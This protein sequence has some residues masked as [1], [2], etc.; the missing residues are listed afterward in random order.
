MK[1]VLVIRLRS[2]GDTV[3]A[4]PSLI[5]LKRFLPHA[6]VDI[7]LEDWVAPLLD[8]FDAVEGVITVGKGALAKLRTARDI[9]RRKYDVV[10]NLHGG[11]T[12][13][14]FT[15]LSGARHRIGYSYYQYPFLYNHLLSSSSDFWKAEQTHSAEQQLALLG[16]VGVPVEDRPRSRLVVT[17]SAVESLEK[18]FHEKTQGSKGG[19]DSQPVS[20]ITEQVRTTCVSGWL[21]IGDFALFHPAAAFATKQWAA[22]NFARVAEYLYDHGLKTVA[23]AARNERAVLEKMAARSGV[24]VLTFD[25][26]TLPEITALAS[27]AR[28]FVGNDSGIAHIAAAVNTPAV[29]IFGSSNIHHWR[30]WTDAPSE[31][32][33]EKLPCQP[34]PGYECKEFGDPK[35]ILSVQPE[36]VFAAIDKV[37]DANKL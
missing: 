21:G 37:L 24:P 28:L 4:T 6:K 22:E 23:V 27:K 19:F 15:F 8:G 32:V 35:C 9:R 29:V 30:P 7:L 33:Y 1:Q 25:D 18:K 14:F 5:A 3:L 31:I 20:E 12:A 2:I 10:I 13:T 17:N 16:F 26:L 11:T 36:S 34:C